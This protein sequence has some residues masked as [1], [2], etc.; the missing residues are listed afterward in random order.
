MLFFSI[1]AVAQSIYISL[2]VNHS[3]LLNAILTE[4]VNESD[5][6]LFTL[7]RN[8]VSTVAIPF[9]NVKHNI[10]NVH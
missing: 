2:D 6:T 7:L 9:K 4:L 10:H 3:L 8:N 1:K 5:R